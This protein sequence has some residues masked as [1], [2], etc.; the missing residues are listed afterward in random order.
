MSKRVSLH[1]HITRVILQYYR[2]NTPPWGEK[3]KLFFWTEGTESAHAER[4][5][6]GK[7]SK[8][9]FLGAVTVSLVFWA[10]NRTRCSALVRRN[11]AIIHMYTSM[12][13]ASQAHTTPESPEI[14]L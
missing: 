11:R 13:A 8:I 2:D 10:I 14:L 12:R 5:I 4:C 7:V 6:Y 1:Y 3:W 9:I